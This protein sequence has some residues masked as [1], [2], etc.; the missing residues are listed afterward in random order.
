[1]SYGMIQTNQEATLVYSMLFHNIHSLGRPPMTTNP[2][3]QCCIIQ[4]LVVRFRFKFQ[5]IS[6]SW[7]L[8]SLPLMADSWTDP[9][10]DAAFARRTEQRA[11]LT[12]YAC[13]LR[14]LGIVGCEKRLRCS[15][16][17]F[18]PTPVKLPSFKPQDSPFPVSIVRP[19][20]VP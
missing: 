2:M 10:T 13:A 3:N 20:L 8:L 9:S 11:T 1:M 19:L 16:Y 14:A 12:T 4:L 5:G 7:C 15:H 18:H 17:F 6:I